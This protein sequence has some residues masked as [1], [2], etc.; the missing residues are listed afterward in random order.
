MA[1]DINTVQ[2]EYCD[3]VS[4]TGRI[5]SYTA[6]TFSESLKAI[7][8]A[9]RYNIVL[10]LVN[11]NYVSSAGLRLLIDIQ[12]ACRYQ[13]RGETCLANVPQRVFDTL[14]LAGFTPLFK[15]FDDVNTAVQH[16]IPKEA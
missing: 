7:T 15:I 9:G 8:D 13:K 3:V 2:S 14:E 1:I 10:D 4:I 5:D 6:P 16:F 12:K 11:V